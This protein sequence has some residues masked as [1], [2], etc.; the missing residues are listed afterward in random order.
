MYISDDRNHIKIEGINF[1]RLDMRRIKKVIDSKQKNPEYNNFI[2][3]LI[4]VLGS[5]KFDVY[6]P[7]KSYPKIFYRLFPKR[8]IANTVQMKFIGETIGFTEK[9]SPWL[10]HKSKKYLK[11]V[12]QFTFY[13]FSYLNL[14]QQI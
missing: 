12:E 10:F 7:S 9:T 5:K 2:A 8:I 11:K 4:L 6:L 3:T 14:E 13:D 1:I